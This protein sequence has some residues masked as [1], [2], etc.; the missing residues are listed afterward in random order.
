MFMEPPLT[1]RAHV[2]LALE[3]LEPI[4]VLGFGQLTDGKVNIN[5]TGVRSDYRRRGI[6]IALKVLA[7]EL[8]KEVGA[9]T[10]VTQNHQ[11]NP[12]LALNLKLG[13]ERTDAMM[14]YS[15]SSEGFCD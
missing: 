10:I 7:I 3:G 4:A 14:E 5:Y 15:R 12:L 9:H 1:N 8:A 2:L 11:D 6:S 13:F